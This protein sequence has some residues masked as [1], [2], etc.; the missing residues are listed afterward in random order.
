MCNTRNVLATLFLIGAFAAICQAAAS[1]EW[2]PAPEPGPVGGAT[3]PPGY[4]SWDLM[5]TVDTDISL[6]EIY[7]Q[8]DTPAPGDFYQNPIAGI[9]GPPS[10]GIISTDSY[11]EFDTYVTLPGTFSVLGAAVDI[12]GGQRPSTFDD[13]LLDITWAV[14]PGNLSGPGTFHVAR[15]TVKDDV[16]AAYTVMGWQLNV[17]STVSLEGHLPPPPLPGDVDGNGFVG[18]DDLVT[19][20]TNWALTGATR[21]QGDLSGDGFVG[22]DDYVEVLTYWADGSPPPEP[23]ATIP[24]PLTLGLLLIGGLP[25]LRRRR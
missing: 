9:T 12:V 10:A 19:I 11:A 7:M 22:A 13:Q 24:E 1:F 4:S 23:P 16:P 15:V 21:Q 17:S 5:Y 18:A 6:V 25:L 14:G 8:S 2:T 20:L 3:Y